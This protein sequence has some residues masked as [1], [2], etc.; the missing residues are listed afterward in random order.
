MEFNLLQAL[1][2]EIGRHSNASAPPAP[3][4]P[5]YGAS[6][7]VPP[8]PPPAP[9]GS[10]APPPPPAPSSAPRSSGQE[11]NTSSLALQMAERRQQL[12]VRPVSRPET[13]K[14]DDGL[15]YGMTQQHM[16]RFEALRRGFNAKP[17]FKRF[18][19]QMGDA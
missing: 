6:S 15:G 1:Q 12:T 4:P 10:S 14:Q 11:A 13:K 19:E 9:G 17:H 18:S 2:G 16:E 7:V 3:S 5:P 8:P